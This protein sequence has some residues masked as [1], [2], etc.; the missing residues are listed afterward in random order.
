MNRSEK[1]ARIRELNDALRRNG[2]GGR[3]LITRGVQALGDATI[4][5]ICAAIAAFDAFDGDNDPHGEHDC[6]ILTVENRRIV[7]KIDYY[8]A[9]LTYGSSDPADPRV[10]TRVLTIMLVEEY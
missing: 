4:V 6:A 3:V 8:D 2:E 9:T 7:W 1:T 10:T 5:A